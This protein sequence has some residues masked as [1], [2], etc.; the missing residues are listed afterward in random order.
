MVTM[1]VDDDTFKDMLWERVQNY[2]YDKYYPESVWWG[3]FDN[4]EVMGWLKPEYNTP[5]YIVDNIAIN[6]EIKP[7]DEIESNYNLDGMSVDEWIED[8]GY[9]VVGDPD[10]QYVIINY[11][12]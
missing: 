5:S 2:G 6:G 4:L 9:Y 7:Y 10:E 8:N 12:L 3:I 11:G 1:K